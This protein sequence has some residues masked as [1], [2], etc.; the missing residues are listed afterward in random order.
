VDDLPKAILLDLDDTILDFSASA[1]RCWQGVCE[2]FAPR[3]EGLTPARLLAAIEERRLWFWAEPER[4]RRGRLDLGQARREIVAAALSQLK[5]DAPVLGNE[6]ADTYA[7]ERE[8]AIELMPG[9]IDALHYLQGQGVRL[10]LITNGTAQAQ[11]L[12]I[13]RFDLGGLFCCIVI[14]G[15]FGVGKPDERVY[16]HALEELKV[17]PEEAWMVGDHLEWDVSAPQ[18]LGILGVWLDYAGQGL[19]AGSQVHPDRI[20][21]SLSELV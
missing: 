14:E 6:V 12:K 17:E 11:R 20:I 18:G 13:D 9:A 3:F 15:E 7:V 8:E 16:L 2:R 19:P 4:H 1:G 10:A 21:R 5:V